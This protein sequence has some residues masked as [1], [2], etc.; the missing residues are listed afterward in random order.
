[1]AQCLVCSS[2]T[3]ERQ[4]WPKPKH[5]PAARSSHAAAQNI[6]ERAGCT[7]CVDDLWQPPSAVQ[8]LQHAQLMPYGSLDETFAPPKVA[9]VAK[10]TAASVPH[11]EALCPQLLNMDLILIQCGKRIFVLFD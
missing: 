4:T 7:F 2:T 10:V 5:T 11:Y 3:E 9:T 6:L 1:M 8:V